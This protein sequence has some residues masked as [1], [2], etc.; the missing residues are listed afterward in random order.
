MNKKGIGPLLLTVA[1]GI[2]V[3]ATGYLSA[4]GSKKLSEKNVEIPKDATIVEKAKVIAP[5]YIPAIAAGAVTIGC[6]VASHKMSAA[7]IAA[8]SVACS[9]GAKK[10]QDHKDDISGFLE[11]VGIKQKPEV[12]PLDMVPNEDGDT[13]FYDTISE[14]Y[15]TSTM[16]EV[17]DAEYEFNRLFALK[18]Y[19]TVNELMELFGIDPVPDGDTIGWDRYAGEEF[20]GY[21]WVDFEHQLEKVD[22]VECYAIHYPFR[23]HYFDSDDCMLYN[24]EAPEVV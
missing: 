6:M 19:V 23:P 1:A 22:D 12:Q 11:K 16:L 24:D 17:L 10:I 20:F 3:L 14:C 21:Q 13:Q 4:R 15:F 5:S 7:Q 2:G 18:D 9:A 8:A